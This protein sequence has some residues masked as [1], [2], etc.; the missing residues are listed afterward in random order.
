LQEVPVMGVRRDLL[1]TVTEG[2]TTLDPFRFRSLLPYV[3]R[4]H[5]EY[6]LSK[7]FPSGP[8]RFA[9]Y[10]YYTPL[11]PISLTKNSDFHLGNWNFLVSRKLNG[12]SNVVKQ[13]ETEEDIKTSPR[14]NIFSLDDEDQQR[15]V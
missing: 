1:Q 13:N 7:A 11:L 4:N 5:P 9:R 10:H 6:E 3:K 14:R 8:A 12:Q 2:K 15:M